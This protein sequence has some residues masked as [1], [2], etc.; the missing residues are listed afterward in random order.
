MTAF[1]TWHLDIDNGWAGELVVSPEDVIDVEGDYYPVITWRLPPPAV[2]RLLH[3]L[4]AL[5]EIGEVMHDH[6]GEGPS[7]HVLVTVGLGEA[8]QRLI[9][10]GRVRRLEDPHDGHV[11][12]DIPRENLARP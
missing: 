8:L 3:A 2:D 1:E 9:E 12:H 4:S 7:G 6:S 5:D 11:Y 10:Q